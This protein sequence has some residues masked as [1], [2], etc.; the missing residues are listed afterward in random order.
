MGISIKLKIPQ[1][2]RIAT[3]LETLVNRDIARRIFIT[4]GLIQFANI[5]PTSFGGSMPNF[6][7]PATQ[8]DEPYSISPVVAQDAEGNNVPVTETFTSSDDTVIQINGDVRSGSLHFGVPGAATATYVAM[9]NGAPIKTTAF[10]FTLGAGPVFS[11]SGG[12]IA[13]P[14]IVP[15]PEPP[16]V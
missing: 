13:F 6:T 11:I 14:N 10:N 5:K 7:L 4:G 3:A 2:E 16:V 9:A 1:L 8:V 12:D 15:D